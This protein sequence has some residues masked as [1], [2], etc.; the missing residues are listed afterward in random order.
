M[1]KA[2]DYIPVS[3]DVNQVV[4]DFSTD[5]SG[6]MQQYSVQQAQEY[7]PVLQEVT[8]V[9]EVVNEPVSVIEDIGDSIGGLF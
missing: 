4:N 2:Q 8:Q 6:Y 1:E 5:P 3:L 7:I 9:I